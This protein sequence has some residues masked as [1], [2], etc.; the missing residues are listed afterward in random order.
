MKKHITK[1]KSSNINEHML[2]APKYINSLDE[3]QV[4]INTGKPGNIQCFECKKEKLIVTRRNTLNR[5]ETI[6]SFLEITEDDWKNE[7]FPRANE[8]NKR[9]WEAPGD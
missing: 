4:K 2:V 3:A 8:E 7:V 1:F 5:E 9:I 6:D